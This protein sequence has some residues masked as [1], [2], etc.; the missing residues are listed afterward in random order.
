VPEKVTVEQIPRRPSQTDCIEMLDAFQ[1]ADLAERKQVF[2][3]LTLRTHP[4]KGG[5]A[6]AFKVVNERRASFLG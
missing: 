4:D 6:E 5:D 3:T 1:G 2:R